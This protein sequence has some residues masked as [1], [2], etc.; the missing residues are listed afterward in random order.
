M[1]HNAPSSSRFLCYVLKLVLGMYCNK[2]GYNLN[3]QKPRLCFINLEASETD[4]SCLLN[5]VKQ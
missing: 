5:L 3:I 2:S 4:E 1:T